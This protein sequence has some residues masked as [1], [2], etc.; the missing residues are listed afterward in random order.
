MSLHIGARRGEIAET[1]FL[2][3]DP[4][5]A[6]WFAKTFLKNVVCY[7]TVRGM[8]GYTGMFDEVRVSVQGTGMGMPSLSIYVNELA[9]YFRVNRMIR[10]GSAGSLQKNIHCR[11]IVLAQASCSD[12]AMLSRTFQGMS[13]APIADFRLLRKAKDVADKLGIKRVKV[14]NVFATDK[15]YDED[16]PPAWKIFARYGVLAIEMETALLYTLA[17]EKGFQALTILTISD[18]MLTGK[19]LSPEEKRCGFSDMVKIALGCCRD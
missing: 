13:F 14:G 18:E 3:G 11:D 5:R 6:E 8:L 16:E 1:V 2:A 9:K 15:F 10:I 17:A 4:L 7:N 19:Q 12:S